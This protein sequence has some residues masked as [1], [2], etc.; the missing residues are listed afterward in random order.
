M[1]KIHRFIFDTDLKETIQV[2]D[3]ALLHQW[4]KVLRFKPGEEI[5]ICDG[6]SHEA[7][8]KVMSLE[9]RIAELE[10]IGKVRDNT[11]EPKRHVTLYMAILKREHTELVV[12]KATECGVSEIVPLVSDRTIKKRAKLERLRDI[13]KEAAEQSGRGRVPLIHEPLSMKAALAHAEMNAANYF[14]HTDAERDIFKGVKAGHSR[15]GLFIGPEGGWSEEEA[16]QMLTHDLH[17]VSLGPRILRG[18]TAAIVSIFLS[19]Q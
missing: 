18:E 5:E 3:Q 7:V 9:K 19:T 13:A 2:R 6:R 10:R 11:A 4:A 17:V 12:Q 15:V 16:E 1:K 14:F 8:Y